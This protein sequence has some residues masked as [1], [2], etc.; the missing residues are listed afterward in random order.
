MVGLLLSLGAL[1]TANGGLP[2]WGATRTVGCF[3]V[4]AVA[5]GGVAEGRKDYG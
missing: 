5:L 2:R 4:L 1:R 3:G